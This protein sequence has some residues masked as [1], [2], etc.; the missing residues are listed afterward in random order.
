MIELDIQEVR[1][2]VRYDPDTG[3]ITR[4][5]AAGNQKAGAN[6]CR[7]NASGYL[8]CTVL[9]RIVKAHRLAWAL[10]HGGW[11]AMTIDHINGVKEDN[12]IVNLRDV[13]RLVNK[14]N[15]RTARRD[16]RSGLIGARWRGDRQTW[17]AE[18]R[19]Q[20]KLI[21]LGTFPTAEAAHQTYLA[22]K[23]R[24]HEGCTL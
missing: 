12:R 13:S 17:A 21:R 22:M 14:Q 19:S 15:M 8:E 6:A 10:H 24:L 5:V 11:P 7:M 4:I 2:F 18:I 20:G 3:A 1:R 9:A 16:S 23:R